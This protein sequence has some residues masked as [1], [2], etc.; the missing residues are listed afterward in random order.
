MLVCRLANRLWTATGLAATRRFQRALREPRQAQLRCLQRL[1]ERNRTSDYGRRHDFARCR[2][3]Q[4]YQAAVPLIRYEELLTEIERIRH[5]EPGVLT[6]EPVLAF[7]RSGGSTAPAKYIPHTRSLKQ[8]FGAAIAPWMADL[9]GACP[10]VR[11]GP[12]YWSVSPL[13]AEPEQTPDGIPV[14]FE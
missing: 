5:G 3:V 11:H 13:S 1:L 9:H 4:E 14:G 10:G 7:E 8:E 6:T 2:T 12:A